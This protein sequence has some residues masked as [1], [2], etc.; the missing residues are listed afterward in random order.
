MHITGR[1]GIFLVKIVMDSFVAGLGKAAEFM[2]GTTSM[3]ANDRN[4]VEK[5]V[6]R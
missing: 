2:V 6:Y 1:C 3:I 4:R 5:R